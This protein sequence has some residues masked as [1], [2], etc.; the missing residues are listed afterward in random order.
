MGIGRALIVGLREAVPGFEP[1]LQ[2]VLANEVKG[3]MKEFSPGSDSNKKSVLKRIPEHGLAPEEILQKME[4]LR[5]KDVSAEDGRLFAFVYTTEK[6]THWATVKK[7]F[8]TYSSEVE[9]PEATKSFCQEAYNM[10]SHENGL[11]PFAFPS[12]RKFETDVISMTASMLNGDANVVGAMTSGG[13]ML[14][15]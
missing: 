5:Q 2:M 13:K 4:E 8:S 11:N 3:A 7:A 14:P 6:D 10:F 9:A 12:L 15:V 1:L